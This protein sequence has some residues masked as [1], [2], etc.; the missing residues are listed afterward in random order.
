VETVRNLVAWVGA[1]IIYFLIWI[2]GKR[3]GFKENS[4]LE[5]PLGSDYIGE[6][7][8]E[9]VAEA[10]GLRLERN[11]CEGGL[12]PDFDS[13]HCPGFDSTAIHPAVREFY[14]QTAQHR[15]DI[16][17]H[18]Y[19]PASIGLWLLVTT[20]SRKVNQLNFPTN[21]LDMAMGMSSEIALLKR[22][23]GSVKYTGWLR[24]FADNQRVLYTGFY[25]V[26]TTPIHGTPVVKAVF[27]MPDGN[28]TVVLRPSVGENGA[29]LL[30]SDG[31]GYG[32]VGFYRVQQHKGAPMRIWRVGSL[33]ENFRVF[34]D[35]EGVVRCDHQVRYL[36]FKVLRL[37]YR[38]EKM[39]SCP[40]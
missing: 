27:P 6:R 38:I 13:L 10:E 36:G 8:Y 16:W 32:D 15:I 7:P 31:V 29:F 1:Q 17:P 28:A 4:W 21:A 5:G 11:A 25:M 3:T 12:I 34:V 30:D 35:E 18:T 33:R 23:D 20:I 2:F 26:G 24:K 40:G 19:F 14:E 39:R 22:D 37:H 9:E